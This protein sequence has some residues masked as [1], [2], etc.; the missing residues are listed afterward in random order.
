MAAADAL[1]LWDDTLRAWMSD[2]AGR[3]LL[4][5]SFFALAVLSLLLILVPLIQRSLRATLRRLA[6]GVEAIRS[7]GEEA[8]LPA[9]LEGEARDLVSSLNRL[10]AELRGRTA[11]LSRR[12][13]ILQT[14]LDAPR[15]QGILATDPE[16]RILLMSA[17]ACALLGYS[18]GDLAGSS[19]EVLFREEDWDRL[20]PKLA[21]RSLRE[22]G[23]SQRVELIRKDLTRFPALLC[24]ATATRPG[25]GQVFVCNFRDLSETAAL[26]R[27]LQDAEER[28]RLLFEGTRDA[29]LVLRLGRIVSANAAAGALL[30]VPAPEL[31]GRAFKE[32][33]AAEDLLPA[34]ER[35]EAAPPAGAPEP[36]P[37]R[38]IRAGSSQL[39][40]ARAAASR[41]VVQGAEAV[42]L[43]LRDE[44]ESLRTERELRAGRALLD[45]TLDAASDAILVVLP[46]G[47][48]SRPVLVNPRAEAFFGVPGREILGWS[49]ER[50]REEIAARCARPGE[51][52]ELPAEGRPGAVLELA[53]GEGRAVEVAVGSLADPG[54]G[55]P[56]RLYTLRDV[57]DKVRAEREL[58]ETARKLEVSRKELMAAVEEVETS[59]AALASRNE[60]L[61]RLNQELRTLD[62]M[63]SNL[64]AN[65]SH[66]LQTPLVLIKGY[67]EMILKR[68]IGPLTPEQEKGLTVALRNIDRLVE[69][70]DNLLD[71]SRLERGEAPLQLEDFPLWQLLDEVIELVREKIRS[72]NI[73]LS[74]QYEADDLTVRADRGKIAQIFL[75]LVSNAIKFNRDGGRVTIRVRKGSR[76]MLDVEVEDTGIG[77][78]PEE[79]SRIFERFYQVDSSAR[80]RHEGTGIGLSIVR[81]ILAMH[82]CSIRVESRVG[83]GTTFF[84]NLPAGRTPA[85]PSPGGFRAA[86]GNDRTPR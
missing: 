40:E 64:L 26:E 69:M 38:L 11:D 70:I 82:G 32:F 23:L 33:V 19:V 74:T 77:I 9:D 72:R 45:A 43:S 25:G 79:Q 41:V 2:P 47:A 8:Q 46:R 71:F 65:V 35:L 68:K 83:E 50:L 67:T 24:V 21:R 59:R 66:E 7:R 17:G 48:H 75:N 60:E 57:S 52:R 29:V 34:L 81:E 14:V 22:T 10:L 63:K 28:G 16:G 31:A 39:R 6:Q 84:F 12:A 86:T 58:R 1:G 85:S 80:K 53:G 62:A 55:A 30:G 61:E 78:P 4:A 3:L 18:P 37:V 51:A 76:G 49:E 73:Y 54:G 27:R 44:T 56:G 42:L 36:F 5:L 20:V 13:D 15:D